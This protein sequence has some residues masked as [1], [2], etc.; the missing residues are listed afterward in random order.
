MMKN[1]QKANKKLELSQAEHEDDR[2]VDHAHFGQ[3]ILDDAEPYSP[4]DSV[5]SRFDEEECFDHPPRLIVY[6][7]Y[8]ARSEFSLDFQYVSR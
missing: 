3:H 5:H 8:S 6:A 2:R 7:D 1:R 4:L